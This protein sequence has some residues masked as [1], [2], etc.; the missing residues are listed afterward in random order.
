MKMKLDPWTS[1]LITRSYEPL[2]REELDAYQQV[3]LM[4]TLENACTG[5]PFYREL[6]GGLSV[7]GMG[8]LKRLPFTWPED[9]GE[10]MICVPQRDIKRVVTLD[11]SGTTG[12]PK[13]IFFTEEDQQLTVDYFHHGMQHIIGDGDSLF[14]GMPCRMPGSVGDLLRI[15]V[16]A[17]GARTISFGLVGDEA[18]MEQA[19]EI[20]KLQRVTSA[21]GLP[22]QMAALALRTPWFRCETALLSAEYVSEEACSI[23]KNQWGCEVFEHY[24]MT[25]MGL[26]CAVSCEIHEGYHVREADLLIEIIDPQSGEPVPDGVW[27]EVVFTTLTRKAMP[28][29]R[30]RTGDIS[31]WIVE[32]CPCGSQLKRLDKVRDRK[33][34][35]GVPDER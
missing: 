2:D 33:M 35:K 14:I 32:P 25:E 21:V 22:S 11:T 12:N 28:F 8:D 19:V 31:R 1:R 15:G 16:E 27:G 23:L 20:L 26:G 13:R 4:E 5:S 18:A 6:L 3:K 30:Y 9:C 24:G 17:F 10:K 7:G 34:A 29:I